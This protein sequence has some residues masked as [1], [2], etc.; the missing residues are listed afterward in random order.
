MKVGF[1]NG[2]QEPAWGN[3]K[4]AWHVLPVNDNEEHE[5]STSCRCNPS[6][7]YSNGSIIIV[8]DA[9]DGRLGIEWVNELLKP[10]L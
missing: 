9:F 6:M 5:E 8:H 3:E 10:E 2:G 4:Q 7:I 1:C